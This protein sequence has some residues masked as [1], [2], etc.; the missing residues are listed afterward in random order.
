MTP[1]VKEILA[2]SDPNLIAKL[3]KEKS[4][5]KEE[6]LSQLGVYDVVTVL[7][8]KEQIDEGG[9]NIRYMIDGKGN[10]FWG[11][12]EK[13]YPEITDEEYAELLEYADAINVDPLAQRARDMS[14]NARKYLVAWMIILWVFFVIG[15]VLIVVVM[16]MGDTDRLVLGGVLFYN[17]I[18]LVGFQIFADAIFENANNSKKLSGVVAHIYISL[19]NAAKKSE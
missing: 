9:P 4:L 15:A 11:V 3:T 7:A 5:A 1:K 14:S 13:V 6:L 19:S 8:T 17:F 2:Q 10:C 12:Q 16:V 18:S